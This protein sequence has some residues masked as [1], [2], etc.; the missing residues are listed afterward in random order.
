MERVVLCDGDLKVAIF[1]DGHRAELCVSRDAEL[2]F[3]LTK[4]HLTQI[5][6]GETIQF[7]QKGIFCKL[8]RDGKTVRLAFAYK[9]VHESSECDVELL[10]KLLER[11]N[12][13][14]VTAVN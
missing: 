14:D 3:P 13:E 2:R 8:T 1:S 7:S 4:H 9:G 10:Q 11:M 6:Q 12:A 5:L